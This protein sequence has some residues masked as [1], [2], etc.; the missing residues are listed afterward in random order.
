MR[1]DAE[2]RTQLARVLG[3]AATDRALGHHVK[4]LED[5]A[6]D[7]FMSM[8]IGNYHPQRLDDVR[9]Y[10]LMLLVK[11]FFDG[12]IPSAD[13]VGRIFHLTNTQSRTLIRRTLATYQKEL[14]D[15]VAATASHIISIANEVDDDSDITQWHFKADSQAVATIN[16][17]LAT[18]NPLLPPI[19]RRANTVSQFV[20]EKPTRSE[21]QTIAR[22]K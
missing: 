20:M 5:V 9:E 21:L 16:E 15:T 6:I 19:R 2:R 22:A 12:Q 13:T 14:D 7:E 4:A 1:N 17:I 11:S 18:R 8:I 3:V 10:R